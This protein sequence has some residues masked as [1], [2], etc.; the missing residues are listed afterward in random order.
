[1]NALASFFYA[2]GR[3]LSITILT[4]VIK[5]LELKLEFFFW[6]DT[7]QSQ[8]TFQMEKIV[9]LEN[10]KLLFMMTLFPLS[11]NVQTMQTF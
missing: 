9:F 11:K 1:M 10:R 6:N 2:K 4:S 7:Y 3:W 8:A 5:E